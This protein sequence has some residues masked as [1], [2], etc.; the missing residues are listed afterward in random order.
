MA[1]VPYISVQPDYPEVL[2]DVMDGRVESEKAWLSVYAS[3]APDE[4]VHARL[5]VARDSSDRSRT[6]LKP[7]TS[8]VEVH[9]LKVSPPGS[10]TTLSVLQP[11]TVSRLFRAQ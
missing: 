4:S 9:P 5:T 6:T 10:W 3:N 1:S 2:Q 7:D 11:H 8:R